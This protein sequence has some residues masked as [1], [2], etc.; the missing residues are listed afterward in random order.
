MRLAKLH[1]LLTGAPSL[2][3]PIASKERPMWVSPAYDQQRMENMEQVMARLR[4]AG[5]LPA[6]GQVIHYILSH[7]YVCVL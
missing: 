4:G 3:D 6:A 5:C 1:A 7:V 2:L